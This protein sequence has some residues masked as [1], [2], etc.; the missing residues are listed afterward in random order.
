ME[1]RKLE[2]L[3]EQKRK[4]STRRRS[5]EPVDSNFFIE[6]ENEDDW[7]DTVNLQTESLLKTD[8]LDFETTT[9]GLAKELVA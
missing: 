5:V 1:Q 6:P 4:N 8:N 3:E 7:I 9:F 2:I